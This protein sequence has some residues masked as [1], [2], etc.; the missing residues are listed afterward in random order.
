MSVWGVTMVKDEADVIEQTLRHM[1]ASG[2]AGVIALDNQS[3]DGTRQ[4]LDELRNEWD[5][6]LR[7]IDDPEV[8]YWQSAKMTSAARMAGDLGAVW[9]VPFD[10]DELWLSPDDRPLAEAIMLHGD[11]V[12][13]QAAQL[14][15]HRCTGLDETSWD[16]AFDDPFTRMRWRHP[17]PLPLPKCVVRVSELRSIHPGNHG[18]DLRQ[19]SWS[20]GLLEVRH[21]P[22]RSP[23]QMLSKVRNGSVAYKATT[24]P[25]TTGQHWR[26]MGEAL[27]AHGPEALAQWFTGAF[28]F[29]TP[30]EAGLIYDP[31]PI[32]L[33]PS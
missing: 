25:R 13:G 21:F 22:Y 12:N 7:V 28:Y 32:A 14:F 26:E 1:H 33:E 24:L 18:A 17:E 27:D 23:N 4:I 3:G 30:A 29:P 16:S 11:R 19:Q 20:D 31:A 10:A 2:L 15:D 9:V 5:G 6:W 8:G